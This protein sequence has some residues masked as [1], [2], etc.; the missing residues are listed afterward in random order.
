MKLFQKSP[1]KKKPTAADTKAATTTTSQEPTHSTLDTDCI[2][3]GDV[4]SRSD[5]LVP[6]QCP[7]P[8]CTA[9]LCSDCL[10]GLVASASDD[11]QTA[12][13]GSRQV[14]T[15]LQCP[16]CRG[17]YQVV[18]PVLVEKDAKTT[19]QQ[20]NDDK[21]QSKTLTRLTGA[22]IV[23][24]VLVLRQALY[25]TQKMT[26]TTNMLSRTPS[27]DDSA[28]NS[29][30]LT[31]KDV[32]LKQYSWQHLNDC[33]DNY[34]LYL[35]SIQLPQQATTTMSS[36]GD[37]L[38]EQLAVLQPFLHGSAD[39]SIHDLAAASANNSRPLTDPTLFL[40]LDELLTPDEQDFCSQ[41]LVSNDLSKIHQACL[42]LQGM[43]Q[44]TRLPTQTNNNTNNSTQQQQQRP[45]GVKQ[46]QRH[47][48]NLD[49]MRKRYPLPTHMPRCVRLLLG[50]PNAAECLQNRKHFVKTKATGLPSLEL[51][52]VRG[53]A[54]RAGLRKGDVVT[55][56]EGE[57]VDNFDQFQVLLAENL[58]A[59][60]DGGVLIG[61]NICTSVAEQ[62]CERNAKMK[63]DKVRFEYS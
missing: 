42:I 48:Q 27:M 51:K 13:D 28:W 22:E 7:T 25:I 34:R 30:D 43:L 12:S 50:E 61:V 44:V 21:A 57:L 26:S 52:V 14:K 6:L 62:L 5:Q 2:I 35:Q 15:R 11:Y 56:V 38:L 19:K 16:M 31:K 46:Q 49:L 37:A 55:H 47:Y 58:A 23:M 60:Y 63:S 54:G 39:Q 1:D 33:H 20:R 24:S 41:L 32:F 29:T 59:S 53:L 45:L 18:V 9:S 3:C 10:E 17:K 8:D 36:R 4:L 40:G